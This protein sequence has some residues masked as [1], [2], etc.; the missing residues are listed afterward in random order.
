MRKIA[1]LR[2]FAATTLLVGA[3]ASTFAQDIRIGFPGPISG[4]ASFLGQQ[5]KW[6][7]EQAVEEINKR[8]GVLGRKV[9]FIMQDS[10]C[11]PA[12][13]V[14]ATEKLISQD[15][16]DLLLGDLCSG[17]TMAVMPLAEKAGKPMIVSISTLPEITDKAGVGGNK[18]VFRTVPED[19]MLAGVIGAQLAKN[20]TIS[21]LA[22]DTDYGRSAV[23]LVKERLGADTKVASEDYVKNTETDFLPLLTKFRSSKPEALAIFMLDQQGFNFMKQ[24]TQ[25]GLTMPLVARPPLVATLVK[26]LLA[27]GKF[28]G[29]WTVYPYYDQL[30]SPANDAF[31]KPFVEKNKQAPHY[32]AYGI[33]ESILV[34]A[35]AIQR[36]GSTE[37]GAVREALTKTNY[38]GILGPIAFDD[39]NQ[40]HNN[41]M[42]MTVE[43][44][45]LS[46]KDL[47]SGR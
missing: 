42:F 3:A 36:A 22:E 4:P 44:G 30:A 41:L 9:A 8:G 16:V 33:Y 15:K 14:A 38:K 26:D 27:T 31:A 20:K 47:V 12:D 46:V 29:S 24:Y 7:A 19:R 32:V 35:D 6:G 13:A 2:A 34:A 28:N 23:K 17:A 43:Q 37:S 18:W 39:H 21:F 25:F 11:R 10:Q 1:L 5:M 45:K 40:A